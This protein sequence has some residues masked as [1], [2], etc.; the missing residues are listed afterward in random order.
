MKE[1]SVA[2]H[3]PKEFFLGGK[4]VFTWLCIRSYIIY[5]SYIYVGFITSLLQIKDLSS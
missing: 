5:D 4:Y 1:K 2:E 3:L